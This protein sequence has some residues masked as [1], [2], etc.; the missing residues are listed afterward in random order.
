MSD[1]APVETPKE[2][3]EARRKRLVEKKFAKALK[4]V[5]VLGKSKGLKENQV[6]HIIDTLRRAVDEAA[7]K[8]NAKAE[9]PEKDPEPVI[10]S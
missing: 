10:P 1:T 7:A 3:K 2:S 8:M 9:P 4:A 5:N 6:S